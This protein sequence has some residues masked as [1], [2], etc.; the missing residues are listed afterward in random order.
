MGQIRIGWRQPAFEPAPRIALADA[1]AG[2]LAGEAVD[3]A[4][5]YL[6][7]ALA[8]AGIPSVVRAATPKEDAI[9]LLMLAAEVEHA[10][11]VQYLYACQSVRGTAA[12][13]IRKVA[14]QEMGHLLTVQNLLLAL[15]GETAEGLPAR[16]HLGRDGLRRFSGRNPLPFM[17]EPVSHVALAKFVVVERPQ[18][19]ADPGLAARLAALEAEATAAGATP[20]PVHALY[21]A[22]RW[23]F[24]RDDVADGS[25]LSVQ[26]G[27]KPGWHL[28]DGDFA[29]PATIAK[30]AATVGEWGGVAGLIVSE[31]LDRGQAL[32]AIDA[33]TAQGEGAPGGEDSHFADF[34]GILDAFEANNIRVKPMPRTPFVADQ[35]PPE[36]PFPTAITSAYARLWGQLF[37]LEYE[38]LLLD[39]AWAFSQPHG[40]G[41]R[42]PMIAVAR[43][44]MTDAIDD[45]SRD[46]SERALADGSPLTAGPP[47]GLAREDVPAGLAAYRGRY[48]DLLERQ[49]TLLAAIERA[50]EF[51]ADVTA[52][53]RLAAI[54]QITDDRQPHLPGG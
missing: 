53:G 11:M 6:A 52:P 16:L 46:I 31:V 24:Q 35:P 19:I 41:G 42:A 15:T 14:V 10:L 37:N 30:F 34:L 12:R 17:L 22:I 39:L 23:L 48:A 13:T 32:G 38:L 45:L 1:P 3:E 18:H 21:A 4:S 33:I 5:R 49:A 20:H 29:D 27:F 43:A 28:A 8:L 36:D 50:P 9:G 26:L 44:S 2:W 25:G 54:R 40:G 47:Y 51:G 7:D